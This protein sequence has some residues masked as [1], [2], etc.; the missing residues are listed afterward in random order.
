MALTIDLR[1]G[2][3]LRDTGPHAALDS[4]GG[5]GR[6]TPLVV[7]AN[8]LPITYDGGRPVPSPG[9]LVAALWPMLVERGGTWIG[10]AGSDTDAPEHLDGVALRSVKLSADDVA[11]YYDGF[12]NNTLWPLFHDAIRPPVFDPT[13]WDAYVRVNVRFA[14]E[15]A[16]TAPHGALVWVQDYH[17]LLVPEMLRELR[18]DVRIGFFLHIPFPPPELFLQLPW[19]KELLK[20]MLGADVVG[21][22]EPMAG[23]NFRRLARFVGATRRGTRLAYGAHTIVV[24]TFPVS[25]DTARFALIA[26]DEQ[27]KRRAAA[28][29]TG[30]GNPA[31]VLLG[32]DRLDYTKGI[33]L[34][35]RAFRE[36]LEDGQLDPRSTVLVQIAVPS[37][38]N[39]ADYL[40]Q[41][42][43][44]ERLVGEINGTFGQ[45]GH[46]VVH[47]LHRS[48]GTD[49]LVA[50]Y[51]SADVMLVTP[52]RDG[53]NLV[54]KEYVASRVDGG[55]ALVLSEFAG[56]ARELTAAEL[57]NPHDG[58]SV[59]SAV[60]TA[61]RRPPNAARRRM[62]QMQRVVQ[63]HDVYAWADSFLYALDPSRWSTPGHAGTR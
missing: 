2:P 55:G 35:L 40:D 23:Q 6:P 24:G 32:V 41:R 45:V 48:V 33:D 22:Q 47:Y 13:W 56:A 54:A 14:N 37:R 34:R 43:R 11:G 19:R 57:V 44:V 26:R 28:I 60:L 12:A 50:L 8:R 21:F 63:A 52:L 38:E 42:E 10:W 36:L 25:I 31:T 39:V 15:V 7:V 59:K 49:E 46:P 5:P 51:R 17:L 29:R 20:G 3:G 62:R 9:G 16:A 4:T 18:P 58:E 61:L 53:M 27:V 1:D 30:L